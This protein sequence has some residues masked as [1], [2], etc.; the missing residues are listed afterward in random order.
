MGW[1]TL[2]LR[3]SPSCS[4]RRGP[5]QQ[6]PLATWEWVRSS[7]QHMNSSHCDPCS[8]TCPEKAG[9]HRRA[10]ECAG[11]APPGCHCMRIGFAEGISMP[12]V[13][14]GSRPRISK[15]QRYYMVTIF[16]LTASLLYADQNL[17]APNLTLIAKEF[18]FN[19]EEKTK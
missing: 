10:T 5:C 16:T 15:L 1:R 8:E 19:E 11:L 2:M 9:R 14:P 7:S 3:R 12:A 17:M 4:S 6:R 13:G 18:G